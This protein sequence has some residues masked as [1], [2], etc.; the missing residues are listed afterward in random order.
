MRPLVIAGIALA[1]AGPLAA[2]QHHA[3]MH[4]GGMAMGQGHAMCQQMDMM[5]MMGMM[6]GGMLTPILQF[7]PAR[8]LSHADHLG[9]TT[10]QVA[11]LTALRDATAKAAE[12][13][14]E[15]AMAAHMKLDQAFKDSPQDTTA[16][17]QYFMAHQ[18]AMSNTQWIRANAALQARAILTPEQR[19]KIE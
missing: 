14:H 3:E 6:G 1:F 9:L 13:A 2:Q 19:M 4:P 18:T 11:R 10:D 16:I 17:R 5:D 8:L 12:Q 15:P 7:A